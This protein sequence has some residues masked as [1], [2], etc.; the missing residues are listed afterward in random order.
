[1][2]VTWIPVIEG[3]LDWMELPE[4]ELPLDALE[5]V[6]TSLE[7]DVVNHQRQPNAQRKE[8]RTRHF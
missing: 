2:L 7:K 8:A 1:M 5:V 6:S 3:G 4:E